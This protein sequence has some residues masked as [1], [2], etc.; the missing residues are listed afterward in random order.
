MEGHSAQNPSMSDTA[1]FH[2]GGSD[3][4][5]I[6]ID[7]SAP[8]GSDRSRGSLGAG[9]CNSMGKSPRRRKGRQIPLRSVIVTLM[10]AGTPDGP[11]LNVPKEMR[12]DTAV[13]FL[14]SKSASTHMG[15]SRLLSFAG[16]PFCCPQ[17][18]TS[19]LMAAPSPSFFRKNSRLTLGKL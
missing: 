11:P 15:G 4:P 6:G 7:E 1:M 14:V 18:F 2:R 17:L 13:W 9:R 16:F 12:T 3:A 5:V 8:R 19:H 10:S